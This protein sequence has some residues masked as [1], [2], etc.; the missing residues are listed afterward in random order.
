[1]GGNPVPDLQSPIP[2]RLDCAEGESS[3]FERQRMDNTTPRVAINGLILHDLCR[4][5]TIAMY[6]RVG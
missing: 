3:R 6:Y 4:I 1:M 5:P 2:R